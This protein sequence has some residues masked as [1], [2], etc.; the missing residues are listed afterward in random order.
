MSLRW[1]ENYSRRMAILFAGLWLI[2]SVVR[3]VHGR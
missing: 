2:V 1:F 3:E